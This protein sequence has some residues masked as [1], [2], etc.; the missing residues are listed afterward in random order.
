MTTPT[1]LEIVLS[2]RWHTLKKHGLREGS[3]EVGMSRVELVGT[4]DQWRAARED[5]ATKRARWSGSDKAS[6][7]AALRRIDAA[8]T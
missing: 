5:V 6:A 4:P 8:L 3:P 7:T 1:T 2:D